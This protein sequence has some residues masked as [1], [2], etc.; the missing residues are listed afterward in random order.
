MKPWHIRPATAKDAEAVAQCYKETYPDNYPWPQFFNPD[1]IASAIATEN[2][3]TY[4][5][6]TTEGIIGTGSVV[7]DDEKRKAELGRA[8]IR[9]TFRGMRDDNSSPFSD[10][11][12]RRVAEAFNQGADLVYSAAV[13]AHPRSQKTLERHGFI[14][15]AFEPGKYP[16]VFMSQRESTII[17]ISKQSKFSKGAPAYLPEAHRD[18]PLDVIAQLGLER[19]NDQNGNKNG[20]FNLSV[21]I[22][23]HPSRHLVATAKP[24]D[25]LDASEVASRIEQLRREENL[26]YVQVHAPATPDG[27]QLQERLGYSVT[28]YLPDWL[29]RESDALVLTRCTAPVNLERV[30]QTNSVSRFID[31]ANM[32]DPGKLWTIRPAQVS[33][34]EN[35]AACFEESYRDVNYPFTVFYDPDAVAQIIATDGTH[36]FVIE[37]QGDIIGTG[38]VV[39]D[40]SG[41]RAELGRACIK[42]NKRGKRHNKSSPFGDLIAHRTAHALARGAHTV[43]SCAV[44]GHPKSQV[45][46]DRFGYVPCG[47][48]SGKYPDLFGLD[49]RE[50]TVVMVYKNS[51]FGEGQRHLVLPSD[52]HDL[53]AQNLDALALDKTFARSG[54]DV[55]RVDVTYTVD[56][57]TSR[58]SKFSIQPGNSMSVDD[59]LDLIDKTTQENNL[60]YT[61]VEI[62]AHTDLTHQLHGALANQG[63][64]VSGFLPH[65][66]K[67]RDGEVHDVLVMERS[68]D[69]INHGRIAT[70][71]KTSKLLATLGRDY[72]ETK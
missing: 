7:L 10:L 22:D 30:T 18:L 60:A 21:A 54:D 33:D 69:P 43:Y 2:T 68:Q 67:C 39:M 50:T 23:T 9:P 42:P 41:T 19:C 62:A 35:L 72:V 70:Y 8:C 38:S 40:P 12:E 37:E 36:T 64:L 11:I 63:Y 20:K 56:A 44:S 4:V 1:Q 59:A 6:E 45:T 24:G 14:P 51:P 65:W 47:I 15:C 26:A 5:I 53:A 25:D 52:V 17:M 57:E 34:A 66:T 28:G 29:A 48:E 49:Q 61:Q 27:A 31:R 46:L 32:P 16:E 3:F 13:T 58:H 55:R 71:N